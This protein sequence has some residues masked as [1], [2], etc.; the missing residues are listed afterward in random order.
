MRLQRDFGTFDE[1]QNDFIATC[2]VSKNG[3]ACTVYSTFLQKYINVAIDS[4]DQNVLFGLYPMIII[5]MWEH[6]YFKDYL[7]NKKAYITN[8][9]RELD[10]QVIEN[11]F[12]RSDKIAKALK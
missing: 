3:W 2:L 1:W 8:M 7:D 4:H 9:M 6:A 5:D 11:R 10:W 12:K